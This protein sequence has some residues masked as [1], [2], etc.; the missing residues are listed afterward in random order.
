MKPED[1]KKWFALF[2]LIT[3]GLST[4]AFV[5]TGLTGSS[6]FFSQQQE[7]FKP[8]DKYVL[9]EDV[10]PTTE[11]EYL[12]RGYTLLKFYYADTAPLYLE[13]LPESLLADSQIQLV[14]VRIKDE[15]N[16]ARI[17]NFQNNKEITNLTEENMINELCSS[18][19]VTPIECALRGA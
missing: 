12:K 17:I 3:F 14:V 4:I 16:Y 9:D 5:I 6:N 2:I 19:I 10:D 13:A 8:L 15:N 18:L 11:N 7:Q 1:K